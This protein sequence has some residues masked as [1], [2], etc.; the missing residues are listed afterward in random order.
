MTNIYRY[1]EFPYP[2]PEDYPTTDIARILPINYPSLDNWYKFFYKTKTRPKHLRSLIIG[3]GT[4]EAVIIA[5]KFR[6]D[7]IIGIDLSPK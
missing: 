1:D 6:N 5:N 3:C 7:D 4:N 2:D